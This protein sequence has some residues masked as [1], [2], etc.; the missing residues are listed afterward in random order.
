LSET[1]QGSGAGASGPSPEAGPSEEQMRAYEAELNRITSSEM[2]L[3]TAVSLVNIGGRR[4]G[5]GE[6]G[7]EAQRDLEQVADAIDA[8]R[9]LM[10]ILERRMPR[11]IGPLRDA[12]S[13]L[14]MAYAREVRATG[15][16]GA[17]P[18]PPGTEQT[19]GPDRPAPPPAAPD[20]GAAPPAG[21]G[22]R[23]PG[24]AEASGRL[25]VPGR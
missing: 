14:Q 9:A 18:Q 13:Q 5:L 20:R 1:Q 12:I 24:P 2:I 7:S 25:W 21:Q 3:Q 4:L 8:A 17:G 15:E 19:G 22:S 6:G 16:Q 23:R 11:E 10:S